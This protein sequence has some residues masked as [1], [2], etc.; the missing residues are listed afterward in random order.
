MYLLDNKV[1]KRIK[2]ILSVKTSNIRNY[3]KK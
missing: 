2:N 3:V 1:D